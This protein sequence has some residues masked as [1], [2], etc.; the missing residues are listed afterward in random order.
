MNKLY[1]SRL[2]DF[3]NV[4]NQIIES[5][6]ARQGHICGPSPVEEKCPGGKMPLEASSRSDCPISDAKIRNL[7]EVVYRIKCI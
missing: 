3:W 7:K 1:S 6:D 4:A 2:I 5:P